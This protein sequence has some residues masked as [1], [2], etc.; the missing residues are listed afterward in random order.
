MV[1]PLRD[2]CPSIYTPYEDR[3]EMPR[4]EGH[5]HPRARR[6]AF[7]ALMGLTFAHC[8]VSWTYGAAVLC[9]SS[10]LVGQR[11]VENSVNRGGDT[12]YEWTKCT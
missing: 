1:G 5:R 4:Q 9:L 6:P 2:G 12:N 8:F 3:E 11:V 10:L 7:H